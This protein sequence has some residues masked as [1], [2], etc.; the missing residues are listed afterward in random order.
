MM[1]GL[2]MT[3]RWITPGWIGVLGRIYPLKMINR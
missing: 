2:E 1:F 3:L